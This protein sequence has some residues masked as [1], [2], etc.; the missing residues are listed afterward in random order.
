VHGEEDP[1]PPEPPLAQDPAD[2]LGMARNAM[3]LASAGK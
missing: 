1:L 2:L 3:N